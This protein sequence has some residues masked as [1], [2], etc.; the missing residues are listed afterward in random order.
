MVHGYL[1]ERTLLK[2]PWSGLGRFCSYSVGQNSATW[3]LLQGGLGNVVW[4]D[5]LE[6]DNTEIW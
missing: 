4:P 2:G 3:L 5:A 6:E 1:Q